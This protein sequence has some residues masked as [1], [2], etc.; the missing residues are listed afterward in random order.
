MHDHRAIGLIER[1][2]QTMKSPLASIKTAAQNRFNLKASIK[3]IINQFRISRQKT[4]NL[5][6]FEAHFERKANTPLS[7]I[8]T[9]PNPITLTYE[10]F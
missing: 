2:I 10:P 6:P 9:E 5:S 1:L 4:I 7:N 8:S 3:S